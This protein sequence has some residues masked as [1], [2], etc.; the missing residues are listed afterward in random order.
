MRAHAGTGRSGCASARAVRAAGV[1]ATA[2]AVGLA[3]LAGCAR[4]TRS[5][6]PSPATD[7]A[8]PAVDRAGLGLEVRGWV[9][10]DRDHRLARALWQAEQRAAVGE[11][12]AAWSACG[13]RVLDVGVHE[14]PGLFDTLAIGPER[15]LWLGQASGWTEG[16]AAAETRTRTGLRM[17][18]GELELEAGA[19]RLLVRCWVERRLGVPPSGGVAEPGEVAGT[20]SG[21][22]AAGE[23][24]ASLSS[25]LRVDL[26]PQNRERTDNQLSL[27]PP[28]PTRPLELGVT[29]DRLRSAWSSDG[30]RALVLVPASP[31]ADWPEMARVMGPVGAEEA[32]FGPSGAPLPTLGE[33]MLDSG[34]RGLRIVLVLIPRTSVEASTRGAGLRVQSGRAA[35]LPRSR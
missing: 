28:D 31:E 2:C 33:A 32:V 34:R 26:L 11:A 6:E 27:E 29:F 1:A 16:Y 20:A 30:S 15:R 24:G 3:L 8:R 12:D 5:T 10:D 14:L 23:G 35:D 7:L 4:T 25:V 22:V 13:V 9:V 18:E 21:P 19:L 17:P